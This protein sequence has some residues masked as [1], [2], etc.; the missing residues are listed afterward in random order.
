MESLIFFLLLLKR[1]LLHYFPDQLVFTGTSYVSLVVLSQPSCSITWVT[2]QIT[3]LF[4][5]VTIWLYFYHFDSFFSTLMTSVSGEEVSSGL[6]AINFEISFPVSS[7][8]RN[9]SLLS[10]RSLWLSGGR[11]WLSELLFFPGLFLVVIGIKVD[12]HLLIRLLTFPL[13]LYLLFLLVIPNTG[14][15]PR[16]FDKLVPWRH[17]IKLIDFKWLVIDEVVR[18][19]EFASHRIVID[20][21]T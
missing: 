20:M 17:L 15:F 11:R 4:S 14:K 10:A 19:V 18:L 16:K 2:H 7:L 9:R 8:L 21:N 6:H 1:I 12:N 13:I 3:V 5:F